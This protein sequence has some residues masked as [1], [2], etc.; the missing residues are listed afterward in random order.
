MKPVWFRVLSILITV[1]TPVFLI[2]LS[3]RLLFTPLSLELEYRAPGFPA[4]RYGFT[5][6]DRLRYGRI[7]I[8]YLNNDQGIEFLADLQ[9]P[10]EQTAPAE[11][12]MWMTD[13]TRIY[14][15]RELQ[16]MVDVKQVL[17][18][19][20]NTLLALG[21]GLAALGLWAWRGDWLKDYI[22]GLRRGG[23][24]TII[25]IGLILILVA[26][27]FNFLFETFHR[28]FFASG[29]YLFL[30]S[31]SLIRLFPE[32]LWRD[33]FIAVG[34]ISGLF[35]AGLIVFFPKRKLR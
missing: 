6:A 35:A 26:V 33:A 28:T 18:S 34:V 32:R 7:S 9:F 12:C 11:S 22:H 19:A 16:H 20:M 29:T 8:D 31:D 21:A 17:H 4:D 10:D 1:V 13:C 3:V 2:L 23:W 14:N 15:E 30:Y 27:L 24:L 25:L 5:L